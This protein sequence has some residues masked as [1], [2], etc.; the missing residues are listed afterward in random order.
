MAAAVTRIK[1]MIFLWEAQMWGPFRKP[2]LRQPMS[3]EYIYGQ[4]KKSAE[5]LFRGTCSVSAF[6]C[7]SFGFEILVGFSF[8]FGD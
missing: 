7:I 8:H 2:V 4:G 3:D 6:M 1:G 5:K